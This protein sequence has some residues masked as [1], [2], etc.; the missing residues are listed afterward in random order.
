MSRR[1][2]IFG[3]L[4]AEVI[5]KDRCVKCGTCVAVCPVD[6]IAIEEGAPKLVGTC[7]ACGM[8]YA[9]CPEA[10]FNEEEIENEVFGRTRTK[11][12]ADLG[13][14]TAIY[15]VR[16]N[17]EE[18]LNSCQD[19]GAVSALLTQFLSDGG[20]GVVVTGLEE[21]GSWVPKPV[22]AGTK[23][24]VLDS[25]G[26]KYTSSPTLVGVTSAVKEYKKGKIAVVGT[27]CQIRGLRMIETGD[28]SEANIS[29]AVD[30][31]V[32][33]F[34]MEIFDQG[35]FMEYLENE[36][37][38]ASKVDKFEIK[39]G[40]FIANQKG[41]EVYSVKLSKVKELVRPCCHECGD[42]SSEFSDISVGNV[43]SPDGWSTVVVRTKRGEEALMSAEKSGLV[44]VKPIEEGKAGLGLVTRL[45][46]KKRKDAQ[47][48]LEKQE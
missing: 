28:L 43:G 35:S 48:V 16:A 42:F 1:P 17:D 30:L 34:C 19:G 41:K 44:E 12:E 8:C 32:G 13:V 39:S 20:D 2:K 4:L 47:K 26:T 23:K 9:N 29:G 33:L 18:I 24:E 25:A 10:I 11:E 38:D 45:A 36:G 15:A 5:R 31:K 37:V 40:K 7:I 46:K 22:V 14:H 3:H 6:A 27:P 21:K